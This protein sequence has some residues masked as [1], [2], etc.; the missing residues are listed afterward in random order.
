MKKRGKNGYVLVKGDPDCPMTTA[1]GYAAEH[2][3]VMAKK[4]G[5]PLLA[6][7]NVHHINGIRDDNRPENLEVWNTYQPAGQRVADKVAWAVEILR[8]YRPDLLA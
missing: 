2:R 3:V 8:L 5:R 6:F 7:E 4:L 1:N